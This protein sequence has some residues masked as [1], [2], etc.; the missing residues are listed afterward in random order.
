LPKTDERREG[1]SSLNQSVTDKNFVFVREVDTT[2]SMLGFRVRAPEGG[3]EKQLK[4]TATNRKN[5]G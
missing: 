1:D 3:A 4:D 5:L 2:L